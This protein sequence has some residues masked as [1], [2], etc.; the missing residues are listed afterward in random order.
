[1]RYVFT[2]FLLGILQLNIFVAYSQD[3]GLSLK[4]S[5]TG[6]QLASDNFTAESEFSF[7]FKDKLTNNDYDVNLLAEDRSRDVIPVNLFADNSI[8]YLIPE[9][10]TI[11]TSLF[12]G[13]PE[14]LILQQQSVTGTIT[15][16]T[17]G[18][19]MVGVNI[20]VKGT[21]LGAISDINGRYSLPAVPADATLVFS[22]VGYNQQEI[23]I[24][25]R[26]V[27]DVSLTSQEIG[28]E[29]VVVIGYG[30]QKKETLTGSVAQIQ[31]DAIVAT[32]TPTLAGAIQGKIVGVQIRQQTGEPGVFNSRISIRGFGEPL[33]VI[34]GVVRDGMSDFE[35]LNADD[36]ES[37]SVLKDA[38]ASIYGMNAANGVLIV[39]T[40]KGFAG[41]TEFTATGIYTAKQPTTNVY[42]S[43]VDAYTLR[44]MNN[45]M[46]R[47]S[48]LPLATSESDLAKW[49]AGV[50]PGYTDYNWFEETTRDWVTSEE[51]NFSARGGNDVIT[52]FSSLGYMTDQ[53]Y[54]QQNE[55]ERYKKYTFRTN[56]DAKLAKGL[57]ARFSFSGRYENQTQP[58]QG[59]FWIF[60]RIVAADRGYGAYTLANNGH[61][62]RVPAENTNAWAELTRDIC[63]YDQNI[64]F[65][66]QSTID[67]NYEAP[68]LKGLSFGL[69]GAYDGL[70]G[71]RR[72]LNTPYQLYDYKTDAPVGT[73]GKATFQNTIT[74]MVRK[75][76]Q[77]KISFRTNIAQAHN[78]SATLVNEIRKVDYNNLSG[79]RQYDDLY[80]RDIINQGSLT[81]ASTTGYRNEQA[82]VSF[83][84]RFNYD[85][86]SKY[87]LEFT[88]REDGSYRYAPGRRWAFFP[89][90]QAAWRIGQEGFIKNNFPVISDM[91]LR[92]TWGRSGYD[93]GNAFEYVEGYTFTGVSGGYVLTDGVLTLGM[94]PPGVVNNYLSWVHT[95]SLDLGIDIELWKGKLGFTADYFERLEEGLLATRVATV[96]NTFGAS[97]PQENLNSQETKGFEFMISHRNTIGKLTYGVNAN[98]TYSRL[99]YLHREQSPYRSTWS[100][101]KSGTDGDGRIQG[102]AWIYDRDGI[103]TSVTELEE[104]VPLMGTTLGNSLML[105][106]MDRIV[107]VNGDGIIDGN[108]QIIGAWAGSGFFGDAL[109][110]PLQFGMNMDFHILNFDLII[111]LAGASLFSMNK[112]RYDQWGYGTRYP[113][114][115]SKYLDRWHTQNPTDNPFDPATVWIPGEWEALT[116]N[117]NNQT[118]NLTTDKWRMDATYL[119]LKTI[120]LGYN[121]PVKYSNA[122]KLNNVRAFI[123]C[124]NLFTLCNKNLKDVDPERAEGAYATSNTYPLMRTFNFG[125]EVKF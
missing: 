104:G 15:D 82:Y 51:A 110:P 106:G 100:R 61:L 23:A 95:T 27:I 75:N 29:E 52:F 108:D 20:Q 18:E 32:K 5:D 14:A 112:S 3:T 47:N 66:Y 118:T 38:S 63:G 74:H 35:R 13:S 71:D 87:L 1:M 97:F 39:T 90:F 44:V 94:V 84:G 85:Y 28:L 50:E 56:V 98:M 67:V 99:Y 76:I 79:K 65:Q 62:S 116:A 125:L 77:P 48:N 103:W 122:I 70:V 78:I 64:N 21:T 107:D 115:W 41:K 42:Q 101:W 105:P 73:P 69:L 8:N 16:A 25:G 7:L 31:S 49:K 30:T 58:P 4:F 83:L 11:P 19:G 43:L 53:G 93:A 22:F 59:V 121:L 68:F 80:T 109:N 2:L 102:R 117:A 24:K 91:K 111:G 57:S 72:L 12:P 9:S 34:D 81:N 17:T 33:L 113:M 119:R 26:S 36:I 89:A 60:K 114:Q 46:L 124:F 86:K 123:N 10:K 88:F 54:F 37:I 92:A 6:P 55:L 96:P 120:E 40:K 45:E